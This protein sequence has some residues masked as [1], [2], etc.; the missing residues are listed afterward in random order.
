MEMNKFYCCKGSV[1]NN[2]HSRSLIGH[3]HFWVISPR[4]LT[5]FTRPFLA[6]RRVWAVVKTDPKLSAPPD[7]WVLLLGNTCL[8]SGPLTVT[9]I[10]MIKAVYIPV[11]Y[12][13]YSQWSFTVTVA[14]VPTHVPD[15]FCLH[16]QPMVHSKRRPL[17]ARPLNCGPKSPMLEL[18][19]FPNHWWCGL[20]SG[21]E[22]NHCFLGKLLF[23]TFLSLTLCM[24][25]LYNTLYSILALLITTY[26]RPHS[27]P[28]QLHIS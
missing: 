17:T 5:L 4:N 24:K 27:T 7:A 11:N 22:T 14:T 26:F 21:N 16:M 20:W 13:L 1:R 10:F 3:Y 23:Y 28:T 12:A 9:C 6:G 2:Y 19:S 8:V 15:S 25:E 18:V